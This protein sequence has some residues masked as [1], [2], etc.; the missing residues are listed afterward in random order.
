MILN[1]SVYF[2]VGSGPV[3]L[4]MIDHYEELF[5]VPADILDIIYTQLLDEDPDQL[6]N[7]CEYHKTTMRLNN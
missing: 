3:F 2:K 7:I 4:I 6:N 5:Q 1:R